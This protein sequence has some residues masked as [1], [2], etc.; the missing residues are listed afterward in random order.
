MKNRTWINM[1]CTVL[2]LA[3]FVYLF[4]DAVRN[5]RDRYDTETADEVVEQEKLELKAFLVRDEEYI[6]QKTTGTVVPLIKDGMRVASGDAVARVCASDEDAA[7]VSALLEAKESLARYQEISEQT[8]LNALDMEKL[9]KTIDASFTELV[10]TSNSGDFFELSRN[11]EELENKL[12]SKQILK[13]G[14]IDLTAKFNELN[15]KIQTLESKSINT[16]DVI[17]PLSGYYISNLDGYENAMDYNKISDLT[18]S[19]AE[20]L[21]E[22]KPGDVS[23]QMGKIVGS[24]KW[25][26]VTVMD[27][28]YSLLM[29][30]GEKM[31]INMPYYGFKN[32]DVVVEKISTTQNDKVAVA[33]SCNMMNE[34]YANMRTEDIELVFKEYT[35]YKINSSAIRRE[36]DEKGKEVDV[37]YILRGDIMN[38]RVIDIIYD[39]GDYVIVSEESKATSGYRPIKRYDEV[40][41]KGRNLS[42]GK[43]I[44]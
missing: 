28:K 18:V 8:E 3:T 21:F 9:N 19:E 15:S 41:V 6:N 26:L 16:S 14:T 42:D 35:G 40:I 12:A 10:R 39:A 23:G 43:S 11:I 33:F 17:A 4:H 36:K 2:V 31:K 5:N 44:S 30:E 34:T 1:I 20:K 24:Y 13:D 37:V 38:A 27:S 7:N 29:S 32:V 22:K 25:Y